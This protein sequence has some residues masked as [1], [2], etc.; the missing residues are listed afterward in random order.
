MDYALRAPRPSAL[1]PLLAVPVGLALG[2][3]Q[4]FIA[5]LAA[6]VLFGA[7]QRSLVLK[8]DE[9]GVQLGRGVRYEHG[10]SQAIVTRVPWSSIREVVV[11]TPGPF[12]GDGPTE[13]GVRLNP[14]A[15]LPRGARAIVSDPRDPDAVQPDLRMEVPGRFDRGALDAAV[16]AHGGRVAEIKRG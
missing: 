12:S 11:V 4:L 6:V 7:W 10:A 15:P 1:L 8:V 5:V 13:V 9:S 2:L 14:G 16:S 3:S